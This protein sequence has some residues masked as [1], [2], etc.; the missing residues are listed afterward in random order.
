MKI[1]NFIILLSRHDVIVQAYLAS[2][3][4]IFAGSDNLPSLLVDQILNIKNTRKPNLILGSS[5]FMQFKTKPSQSNNIINTVET[6]KVAALFTLRG[7][8]S[9]LLPKKGE[10]SSLANCATLF[11]GKITMGEF[12]LE[13]L[14]DTA[15]A[16]SILYGIN[17]GFT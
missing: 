14:V 2:S 17:G 15:E 5:A 6:K 8:D 4:F 7:A 3:A 10:L 1:Y 16:S 9:I 11:D 13:S 12:V